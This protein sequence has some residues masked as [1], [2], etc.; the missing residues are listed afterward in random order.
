MDEFLPRARR[1]VSRTQVRV[2]NSGTTLA[3]ISLGDRYY[4]RIFQKETGIDFPQ[5]I[6]ETREG[7]RDC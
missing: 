2:L 6:E 1:A 5:L 3:A 4:A 7:L